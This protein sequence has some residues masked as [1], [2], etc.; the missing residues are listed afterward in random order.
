M[1]VFSKVKKRK[2]E[3]EMNL[4]LAIMKVFAALCKKEEGRKYLLLDK[5]KENHSNFEDILLFI[6]KKENY[7]ELSAF[8]VDYF[9]SL[10]Q[11]KYENEK[12][13][14]LTLEKMF[15][16]ALNKKEIELILSL[17]ANAINSQ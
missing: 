1:R 12:F 16:D 17:S 4:I 2:N 7:Q 6:A 9:Q 8:I 11:Q 5:M 14:A 3:F 15:G 10:V 13:D